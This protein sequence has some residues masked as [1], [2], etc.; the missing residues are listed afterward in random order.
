MFNDSI[1]EYEC[2]ICSG[3]KFSQLWQIER[4]SFQQHLWRCSTCDYHFAHPL[5]SPEYL[6]L[7]YGSSYGCY[8]DMEAANIRAIQRRVK[9]INKICGTKGRLLDV[10]GGTGAFTEAAL[11]AG[12][13]AYSVETSKYAHQKAKERL[14]ARAFGTTLDRLP[15]DMK[16]FD[17]ITLWAVAEHLTDPMPILTEAVSRLKTNG[18]LYIQTPFIQSLAAKTFRTNWRLLLHSPDHVGFFTTKTVQSICPRLELCLLATRT[19]GA[20]F[21]F[22]RAKIKSPNLDKPANA[23]DNAFARATKSSL[24]SILK[25]DIAGPIARALT[26]ALGLGDNI[27]FVLQKIK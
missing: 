1:A 16:H 13:D 19:S 14:G 24:T 8:Q 25:H 7:F 22:G 3:V 6:E 23:N 4:D 15:E 17:A 12:W 9:R 21:P 5:P 26:G 11:S 27:E 18:V 20:P 10:G 2:P